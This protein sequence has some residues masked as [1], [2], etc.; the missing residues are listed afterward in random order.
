MTETLEDWNIPIQPF[1]KVYEKTD[2]NII[3]ILKNDEQVKF[4]IWSQPDF[5]N[6]LL[7]VPT[8]YNPQCVD[9][10]ID[11]GFAPPCSFLQEKL[12]LYSKIKKY[13]I[14]KRSDTI[15]DT[16]NV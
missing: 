7:P 1:K 12:H 11:C 10:L 9:L 6:E 15:Y 14:Q 13:C 4:Y 8:S 3:D 2:S 5:K 16:C